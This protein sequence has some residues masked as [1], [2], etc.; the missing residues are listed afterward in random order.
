MGVAVTAHLKLRYDAPMRK[1]YVPSSGPESWKGFLARPDLHWARGYSARTVAHSWEAADGLPPEIA[2]LLQGVAGPIEL[3]FALP[4]HKTALP[5]GH[6]DSQSDVFALLRSS[7]GLMTATIEGKVDEPFGPTLAEWLDAASPGKVQRLGAIKQMLGLPP[8]IDGSVRY[9]LL[10]RT[11]AAVIE[12]ERFS[13]GSAAMIVHSFSPE[14]RWFDDFARFAGLLGLT[15]TTGSPVT[16]T[17]PNG[18]LLYLGWARGDQ[19]FRAL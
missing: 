14:A 4:E 15:A 10:H 5:G 19:R 6:R 8:E 17:L 7:A 3:L 2:E 18:K 11:A 1:I 9:Q 16:T 12:A 13:A